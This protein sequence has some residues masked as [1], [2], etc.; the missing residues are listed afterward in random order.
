MAAEQLV[1]LRQP[2]VLIVTPWGRRWPTRDEKHITAA[3]AYLRERLEI[4]SLAE[5]LGIQQ[6]PAVDNR[7]E[8]PLAGRLIDKTEVSMVATEVKGAN[9]FRCVRSGGDQETDGQ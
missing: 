9:G 5:V 3:A 2:H 1:I 6:R 7:R 4:F 8:R